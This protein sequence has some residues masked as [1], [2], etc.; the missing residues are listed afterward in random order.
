MIINLLSG[1]RNISTALM[2]SFAQR[3]D[4][5]VIDEPFYGYYLKET[6][7]DHP[8]KQETMDS[9][10][11]NYQSVVSSVNSFSDAP[12]LFLKNMSHHMIMEDYSFIKDW[13]NLL[14]IRDPNQLIA[15]F[16]KVIPN[17]KMT[18]IGLKQEWELYE[19]LKN[20][21][22]EPTVL[23]SNEILKNPSGVLSKLCERLGIP[24]DTNM[25]HW[26]A[27]PRPEDGAWAKFWYNNV[28]KSTGFAGPKA[29]KA[30]V[31]THLNDLLGESLHY[32]NLLQQHSIK[33]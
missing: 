9:M 14:L 21:G 19:Y 5:K 31:P 13:N 28:H 32:F 6:N 15:S 18:D 1:P 12:V 4:T 29:E 17:P 10:D 20:A 8:G 22:T 16:S 11:C 2:Y 27:G 33:A 25:L 23:D 30:I 3:S 7:I 26:E 24:F